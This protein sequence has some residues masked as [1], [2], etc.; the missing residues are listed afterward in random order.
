MNSSFKGG[1]KSKNAKSE[2]ARVKKHDV[3]KKASKQIE[4]DNKIEKTEEGIKVSKDNQARKA[5][6]KKDDE[7]KKA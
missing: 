7:E 4:I 5:E 6:A 3:R 2:T 1:R